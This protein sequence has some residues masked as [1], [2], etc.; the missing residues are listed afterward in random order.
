M[1][2][3]LKG[4]SPTLK[5]EFD[6]DI[7]VAAA[8][9]LG[10]FGG[11]RRRVVPIIGGA[12]TGPRLAGVV[13]P[14]GADWQTIRPDGVTLIEARYTV[15]MSDGWTI[16]VVNTGMRRA[17]PEIIQKIT[18][19]EIVDPSLY[20]F[21]TTPVFEVGRGPYGWLTENIFVCVGE[22]LPSLVRLKI[23]SVG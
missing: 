16:G 2:V 10:E 23:Y 9:E 5:Y 20:Y 13:V 14:G 19:G 6:L 21:R 8:Q 15:R 3:D 11:G 22:R 4:E 7:Q 18:A 17:A 12:L 1:T